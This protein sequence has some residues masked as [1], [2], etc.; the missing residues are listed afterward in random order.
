MALGFLYGA[1]GG[2]SSIPEGATVT[3]V[4]DVYTW[5][6]CAGIENPQYTTLAEILADAATLAHVIASANATDY[7]VRS[8][9]WINNETK[10]PKMTSNTT[11][12]GVVSSS[13]TLSSSFI[14]WYAFDRN[15]ST[16]AIPQTTIGTTAWIQYK[17]TQPLAI[18]KVALTSGPSGSC[19]ASGNIQ[20]SNDGSSWTN[21]GTFSIGASSDTQTW[22]FDVNEDADLYL[23]WRVNAS[24]VGTNQWLRFGSIEFFGASIVLSQTAM[25][26]IG[27]SNYASDTLLADSDWCEAIFDSPYYASVVTSVP[28]MTSDT[29]PSG[30]CISSSYPQEHPYKAFD[31]DLTSAARP[32]NN[33]GLYVGYTFPM[34]VCVKKF[35]LYFDSSASGYLGGVIKLTLQGY[36][37]SSWVDV[38]SEFNIPAL[39][40]VY[41]RMTNET[42]YSGYRII[43][44]T[45]TI[46]DYTIA[47]WGIQFYGIP[48]RT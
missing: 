26:L 2:G 12:S 45:K 4:G 3:P 16:E 37:G 43:M 21:V 5:Q 32:Y 44:K 15:T 35:R 47:F 11:P 46:N 36:N 1:G 18:T 10:V 48:D 29:T 7:L 23:Y 41:D 38:G 39:D 14:E 33:A 24:T 9:T 28:I 27:A 6:R 22:Y 8:K 30:E 31:G 13:A 17:F 40:Y 19:A 20:A 25:A 42:F 34:D